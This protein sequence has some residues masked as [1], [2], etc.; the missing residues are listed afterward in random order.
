MFLGTVTI[1]TGAAA[2]DTTFSVGQLGSGAQ[3]T[4]VT[5][6]TGYTLDL[7][8]PAYT[9]TVGSTF[10]VTTTVPEP[11]VLSLIATG[12]LLLLRRRRTV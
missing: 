4:T 6:T 10:T 2:G 5:N 9:P 3:G 11:A 12:G 7:P 8:D 1:T